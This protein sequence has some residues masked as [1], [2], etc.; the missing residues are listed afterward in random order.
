MYEAKIK[1]DPLFDLVKSLTKTEKA[2]FQK[3]ACIH[4]K[5]EENYYV[6][7]F[8]I[9]DGME[10]FDGAA[11]RKKL[12]KKN[13]PQQLHRTKNYVYNQILNSLR[14]YHAAIT[15]EDQL[16][17]TLKDIEIMY[18]KGNYELCKS[19][20]ENG[21]A[22][23]YKYEKLNAII[24]FL[25]WDKKLISKDVGFKNKTALLSEI[26][27]EHKSLLEQKKNLYKYELWFNKMYTVIK[28]N[29]KIREVHQL[30]DWEEIMGQ[31]I[32]KE[33]SKALT[34]KA[35]IIY[36]YCWG[37]FYYCTGNWQ[38]VL[39]VVKRRF[40]LLESRKELISDSPHQYINILGNKLGLLV[41]LSTMQG[42]SLEEG[43]TQ[44]FKIVKTMNKFGRLWRSVTGLSE[45]EIRVFANTTIHE[46]GFYVSRGEF[47]KAIH[48]SKK[49]ERKMDSLSQ[50]IGRASELAYLYYTTYAYFGAGEYRRALRYINYIL[51]NNYL[52]IR[53]DLQ[54]FTRI[55][56]LMIHY[57]LGNIFV[58][59]SA[60]L[61]AKRFLKQ[62]GHF[63]AY[64]KCLLA[65]FRKAAM[66]KL[67]TRKA[68][69]KAL[70][71]LKNIMQS[72]SDNKYATNIDEYYHFMW[73]IESKLEHKPLDEVVQEGVAN[74]IQEA[75]H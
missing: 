48:F 66:M 44:F 5:G 2:F 23:A 7:L 19:L 43:K 54:C 39:E 16:T 8:D 9:L 4:I 11:L 3:Y 65:F 53:E 37:G 18:G 21:K 33:E 51:N 35:K 60:V 12:G 25:E 17:D 10:Y 68:E 22:L 26:L 30:A 73:W 75:K 52:E 61:H 13:M 62:K 58:L 46:L 69:G 1:D 72:V 38:K 70:L 50:N 63:F 71:S 40:E 31:D 41:N 49:A 64:E 36:N 42:T 34:F 45:I 24:E 20:L 59:E 29:N 27:T 47:K 15:I 55:L 28:S 32:F 74:F 56:N 57:E 14:E 6:K 67:D